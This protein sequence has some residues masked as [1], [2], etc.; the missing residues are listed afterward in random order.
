MAEFVKVIGW[1]FVGLGVVLLILGING[2][3]LYYIAGGM[4]AITS[5]VLFLAIGAIIEN[6]VNINNRLTWLMPDE[7][8]D[9]NPDEKPDKMD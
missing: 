2:E 7:Y 1:I 6:L 5:G 8:F 4:G 9:A 3:T